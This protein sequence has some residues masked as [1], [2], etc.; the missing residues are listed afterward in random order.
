MYCDTPGINVL[1]YLSFVQ[2]GGRS[3]LSLELETLYVYKDVTKMKAARY[4]Q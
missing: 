4:K 3:T 2:F 1:K